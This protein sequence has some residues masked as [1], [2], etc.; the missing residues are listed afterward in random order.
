MDRVHAFHQPLIDFAFSCCDDRAFDT[1]A[2]VN[3][4]SALIR[5]IRC[6]E[7]QQDLNLFEFKNTG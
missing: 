3:K 7:T 1:A 4:I 6:G 2:S 5:Q